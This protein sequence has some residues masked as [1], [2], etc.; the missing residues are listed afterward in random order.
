MD[1]WKQ[2][3][4]E[5]RELFMIL[6]DQ[7]T[8]HGAQY[9]Q[10]LFPCVERL[11]HMT[12]EQAQLPDTTETRS[13]R[14]AYPLICRSLWAREM[15]VVMRG[16]VECAEW[17]ALWRNQRRE[18]L[19][20]C[21]GATLYFFT[22]KMQCEEYL[23]ELTR[24]VDDEDSKESETHK[25]ILKE[26]APQQC[27]E[28]GRN[29]W[30]IRKG[31]KSIDPDDAPDMRHAFALFDAQGKLKLILDVASENEANQWLGAI[32]S[33]L[34]RSQLYAK[35]D[36][37]EY[38]I[39]DNGTGGLK[40]S[41]AFA[42]GSSIQD[43]EIPLRWLHRYIDELSS[44]SATRGRRTSSTMTQAKK[45]VRRDRLCLNGTLLTAMSL[46]DIVQ[47]LLIQ[48]M[49]A[50]KNAIAEIEAFQFAHLL[51][52]SSSRTQGGGDILDAIQLIFPGSH[53][54]VCPDAN[55]M[56]PILLDLSYDTNQTG[57]RKLVA[58]IRICMGYRILHAGQDDEGV[59]EMVKT[60]GRAIAQVQGQYYR[61]LVCD[62]DEWNCLEGV[63][64]LQVI[65]QGEVE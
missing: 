46:E 30:S 58:E 18:Y 16:Y 45:D 39:S 7:Y 11:I 12:S 31:E 35:I 47:A 42:N 56:E 54:C 61:R 60:D 38:S 57:D 4:T 55:V 25:K 10:D 48:I 3:Q 53:F 23:F 13:I 34:N 63:I 5:S 33:E 51:L 29:K 49:S 59:V 28:L 20:L 22:S 44:G 19:C 17:R 43:V 1:Q 9:I 2:V 62:Q 8:R 37:R 6:R 26:N 32:K 64:Q 50:T 52:I 36:Q 41:I 40:P 27:I 65:A 21:D 24:D 14:W 15:T